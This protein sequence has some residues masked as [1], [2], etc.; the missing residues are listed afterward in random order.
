MNEQIS[1]GEISLNKEK[2]L[3]RIT[4][5]HP[6]S[7]CFPQAQLNKLIE[8]LND[9]ATDELVKVIIL[10]SAGEKVFSAGASFDELLAIKGLEDAKIFFAGFGSVILAMRNSPKFIIA[11]VQGKAVGGGVGIIAASD[12]AIGHQSSSVKLSELSIGFGPFVIGPAVEKK[13]GR[14]AFAEL[15]IGTDWRDANWAKEKGLFASVCENI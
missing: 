3:A 12:Y 2:G 11:R 15:S 14:G 9:C 13:I 5:S 10:Q 6:K 1:N 7:N 8:A 4:F